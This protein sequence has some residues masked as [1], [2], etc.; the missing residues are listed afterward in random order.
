M[1]EETSSGENLRERSLIGSKET[2]SIPLDSALSID[3]SGQLHLYWRKRN[4]YGKNRLHILFGLSNIR[5]LQDR[6]AFLLP[7]WQTSEIVRM[8]IEIVTNR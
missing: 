7:L 6:W 3:T 8:G 4:K 2:A 5:D 1:I